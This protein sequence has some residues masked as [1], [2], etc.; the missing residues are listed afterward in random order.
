M[1]L[2]KTNFRHKLTD[3]QF[4]SEHQRTINLIIKVRWILL[5]LMIVY[6]ALGTV[7]LYIDNHYFQLSSLQIKSV[8]AIFCVVILHNLFSIAVNTKRKYKYF[9]DRSQIILD[10]SIITLLIHITGGG[11]SWLWPLYLIVTFESAF[12]LN[13]RRCLVL[14]GIFSSA[15]YALV[16]WAGHHNSY[17]T[18]MLNIYNSNHTHNTNYLILL[19]LWVNLTNIAVAIVGRIMHRSIIHETHKVSEREQRLH[20][21]MDSAQDLIIAFDNNNCIHYINKAIRERLGLSEENSTPNKIQDILVSEDIAEWQ[22]KTCLLS[23]GEKFVPTIFH[24]RTSSGEP[25]HVECNIS[26][27]DQETQQLHWAICRDLSAQLEQDEQLYQIS[28]YDKLTGLANRHS[29]S[30]Q[31]IQS[32]LLAKRY[33]QKIG[34]IMLAVDHLKLINESVSVKSGDDL[35]STFSKRLRN[36]VRGTDI[37]GRLAGNQFAIL[38]IN[39]DGHEAVDHIVDKI[40]E[41]LT[42]PV[43][44]DNHGFFLTASIGLSIFPQHG[45]NIEELINRSASAMYSVKN[46]GGNSA[47]Y[48]SDEMD[49]TVKNQLGMIKGLQTALDNNELQL[50]Y[51]PKVNIN[52]GSFNSVEVLLRWNHPQLGE[53]APSDFIPIAEQSGIIGD[54]T[55]WI[56]YKACHQCIEWQQSSLP[57]IT[58][59]VNV[60]GHQLQDRSII[61]QIKLILQQTGMEAQLLEIEITESVL[62]QNPEIARSVLMELRNLGIKVSID[63]FGTGYS[64]LAYLKLF[65]VNAIKIDRAFIIDVERSERYAALTASIIKMGKTLNLKIIAEGVETLG[66]LEFLKEHDCDEVQGYL[67]STPVTAEGIAILL[68][69]LKN[70]SH[71]FMPELIAKLSN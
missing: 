65:P 66:Q 3:G 19:W 44:I 14:M 6:C 40:R 18:I 52:T 36:C 9:F 50:H 62:M 60:S 54:L 59:A 56:L 47:V 64:S 58:I 49:V 22:R 51:Q 1:K 38:L 53:V 13:F 7:F 33:K 42:E 4:I 25:V 57:P 29:F 35:L 15:M 68:K 10:L 39:V 70:Q 37:V 61:D 63:D 32:H 67:Y 28:N 43:T 24:L 48:Y 45:S 12:L 69:N 8:V 5:V 27:D 21:Y 71:P 26:S 11:S 30:E 17:N 20:R 46:L 31:A 16:L 23:V 55:S 34:L 2:D 41:S